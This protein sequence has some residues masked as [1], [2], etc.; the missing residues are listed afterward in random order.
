[1]KAKGY[2]SRRSIKGKGYKFSEGY[3]RRKE[4]WGLMSMKLSDVTGKLENVHKLCKSK[5][6]DS[7]KWEGQQLSLNG[8]FH[9]KVC[10]VHTVKALERTKLSPG[11][12]PH[13]RAV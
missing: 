10:T 5:V 4:K 7:C 6:S 13:H 11:F 9:E 8:P 1:M 12:E 3:T 2:K